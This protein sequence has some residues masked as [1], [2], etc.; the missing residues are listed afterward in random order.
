VPDRHRA[1]AAAQGHLP[2]QLGGDGETLGDRRGDRRHR[3]SGDGQESGGEKRC[4]H[5]RE[6]CF[7]WPLRA[8]FVRGT[9]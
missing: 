6:P 5:I 1:R 2:P 8:T 7:E 9:A 3:Q 4:E